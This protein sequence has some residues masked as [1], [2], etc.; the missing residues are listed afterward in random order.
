MKRNVLIVEDNRVCMEAL[1]E[2]TRK[3]DT[4]GAVFALTIG[5]MHI[6]VQWKMKLICS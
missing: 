4:V 3:C 1:A 6:P 2:L 5:R